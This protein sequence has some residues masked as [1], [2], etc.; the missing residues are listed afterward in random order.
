MKSIDFWGEIIFLL[1]GWSIS[2]A[3]VS[4]LLDGT[5]WLHFFLASALSGSNQFISKINKLKNELKDLD[6]KF[7]ISDNQLVYVSQLVTEL[8]E[9]RSELQRIVND[10]ENR[11]DSLENS[12][13]F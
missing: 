8:E 12:R 10:L 13:A 5:F 9:D 7:T 11:I 4:W 1:I 6:T 2:F 3:I